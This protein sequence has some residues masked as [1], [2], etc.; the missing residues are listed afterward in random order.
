MFGNEEDSGELF[1]R[2]RLAK[3]ICEHCEK[4]RSCGRILNIFT[5]NFCDPN[6]ASFIYDIIGL[7]FYLDLQGKT[8]SFM[9]EIRSPVRELLRSLLSESDM[10]D[11][12]G[13]IVESDADS[14]GNLRYEFI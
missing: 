6:A 13:E 11:D 10:V 8:S 1:Y 7:D 14:D 4:K 2:K 5:S 12:D 3:V 9:M